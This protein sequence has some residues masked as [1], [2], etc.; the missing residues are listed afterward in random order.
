MRKKPKRESDAKQADVVVEV[1]FESDKERRWRIDQLV[2]GGFTKHQ[3][4]R[5]SLLEGIDYRRAVDMLGA[6]A[7]FTT[8]YDILS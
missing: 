2:A 1:E 8:I 6:G 4:Y 5:L 7:D 3:A